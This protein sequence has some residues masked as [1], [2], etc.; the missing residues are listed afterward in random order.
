MALYRRGNALVVKNGA[1]RIDD[2]QPCCCGESCATCI[3]CVWTRA[4]D[5]SVTLGPGGQC[6]FHGTEGDWEQQFLDET[7]SFSGSYESVFDPVDPMCYLANCDTYLNGLDVFYQCVN[8][9]PTLPQDCVTYRGCST[10]PNPTGNGFMTNDLSV[11]GC[12]F[13]DESD[14]AERS[15]LAYEVSACARFVCLGDGYTVAATGE[16]VAPGPYTA[17]YLPTNRPPEFRGNSVYKIVETTGDSVSD[18]PGCGGHFPRFTFH[19]CEQVP[20]AKFFTHRS[21]LMFDG[22]LVNGFFVAGCDQDQS[23]T[24]DL[25]II[26]ESNTLD[27]GSGSMTVNF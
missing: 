20:C 27:L 14:M 13:Y 17:Y 26:D 9:F 24:I 25:K 2:G 8:L 23:A 5:Y 6:S 19:R 18:P 7:T 11:P 3:G 15:W 4:P 10:A 1:L 16:P 12:R 21:N 22:E